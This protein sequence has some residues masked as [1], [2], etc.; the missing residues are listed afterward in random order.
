MP[1]LFENLGSNLLDLSLRNKLI[2]FTDSKYR[3]IEI[4]EPSGEKLFSIINKQTL[5]YLKNTE[6]EKITYS[7]PKLSY[8]IECYKNGEKSEK[9]YKFLKKNND[10]AKNEKGINILYIAFGLLN[11]KDENYKKSNLKSPLILIPVDIKYSF[12]SQLYTLLPIEDEIVL[13]PALKFKLEYDHGI[14]IP[15]FDP[16][17]G[18]NKYYESLNEIFE[19][20]NWFIEDKTFLGLFSFAKIT[21]YKDLKA[22]ETQ[23]TSTTLVETIYNGTPYFGNKLKTDYEEY[24]KDGKDAD[25]H[26]VVDTDSSQIEA[27]LEAKNG[28]SFVIQ[29]PPGTG[30]SQTITNIIAE[31]IN[32]KKRVLFVSEKK[33]ALDVV[34]NNLSKVGLN[35]FCLQIHSDKTNKKEFIQELYRVYSN[36]KYNPVYIDA[37]LNYL[38]NEKQALDNYAYLSNQYIKELNINLIDLIEKYYSYKDYSIDTYNIKNINNKNFK[39]LESCQKALQNLSLFE[40]SFS[41]DDYL[42]KDFDSEK[43]NYDNKNKIADDFNDYLNI[44]SNIV[45]ASNI[46][47]NVTKKNLHNLNNLEDDFEQ[48]SI[49]KDVPYNDI[50]LFSFEKRKE[51]ISYFDEMSLIIKKLELCEKKIE[52]IFDLNFFNI[53]YKDICD[54]FLTKYRN[55]FLTFN[56]SYKKDKK[57][58]T[59]YI[60]PNVK[61]INYF[62]LKK[63]IKNASLLAECKIELENA[64]EH[65]KKISKYNYDLSSYKSISC[66]YNELIKFDRKYFSFNLNLDEGINVKE[67]VNSAK[68]LSAL[69]T[70]KNIKKLKT[71]NDYFVNKSFNVLTKD[72]NDFKNELENYSNNI[73]KLAEW[74]NFYEIYKPI[75]KMQLDDFI[76]NVSKLNLNKKDLSNIY[77]SLFYKEWLNYIYYSNNT[78]KLM[79]KLKQN[80]NVFKFIEAD[81]KMFDVNRKYII[82][83]IKKNLNDIKD[84][85][86]GNSGFV[87]G[88]F[89]PDMKMRNQIK[90]LTHEANKKRAI[91]PIR[92]VFDQISDLLFSIKPCV[93]MSPV[94]VA[95][96]LKYKTDLFDV[97]IFDEASQ[98]FP[99]DAVGSISRAKSAII[100]GDS[101]QM[102]PSNFFMSGTSFDEEEK[103]EQDEDTAKDFESILDLA[104]AVFPQKMLNWHYRSK[105][106]SLIAFSNHNFYND[107]LVTFPS[108][109]FDSDDFGIKFHYVEN[110]TFV[111][112]VNVE[113]ANAVAD[114]VYESL[115][116]YPDKSI[117]VVCFSISQQS[118]LEDVIEERRRKNP[119]LDKMLTENID[120]PFFIKNLETVQGDERDIIIFSIGYGKDSS[121][122]F[123]MNFGPL[124]KEG[125]ERRLNVAI[126]RAK[127]SVHVVSSIRYSDID[128]SRTSSKGASLLKDYLYIAE[129]GI[130]NINNNI[131][132][133]DLENNNISLE[134]DIANAIKNMGYEAFTKIGHSD[135]KIDVV[136][137]HPKY[138]D[139]VLAIECDG[140]TYHSAKNTRDRDRLRQEVLEKQGW[141]FYRIWSIDWFMYPITEKEYLKKAIENAIEKYDSEVKGKK[142]IDENSSDEK[143]DIFIPYIDSKEEEQNKRTKKES[144][145]PII[146]PNEIENK[147][148]KEFT[149]NLSK[150]DAEYIASFTNHL[151]LSGYNFVFENR[152][153][154]FAYKL[155]SDI[156]NGNSLALFWFTLNNNRKLVL[157]LKEDSKQ[158]YYEKEILCSEYPSEKS[159][160]NLVLGYYNK[161]LTNSKKQES[162]IDVNEQLPVIDV[163]EKKINTFYLSYIDALQGKRVYSYSTEGQIIRKSRDI[164]LNEI[165]NNAL[166]RKIFKDR[167]DFNKH[168]YTRNCTYNIFDYYFDINNLNVDKAKKLFIY[169]IALIVMDIF[170]DYE[171]KL[172]CKIIDD[173]M[174]AFNSLVRIIESKDLIYSKCEGITSNLSFISTEMIDRQIEEY[175][176]YI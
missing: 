151:K 90:I 39:Y 86:T 103:Y 74:V 43:Y 92:K 50:N 132:N 78:F 160:C 104:T 21:M 102:P 87:Y 83:S 45:D 16:S 63:W 32:D 150:K 70:D 171:K 68:S 117:G 128:L 42:W 123:R 79:S 26:N 48:I 137:K 65:I 114:L 40:G 110:G 106:E 12:K 6:D 46:Y 143:N 142:E 138:D 36:T 162:I 29:G 124:N 60:N 20:K 89:A 174:K 135:Y 122:F 172:R 139:Y 31:L 154:I 115:L 19:K 76:K 11:W 84:A 133:F 15:E 118:L 173:N 134:E 28:K 176:K 37:Q 166:G 148:N 147:N 161:K 163:N 3:S 61:H 94:S 2:N 75:K 38:K 105:S 71:I 101:K 127:Y 47:N 145:K 23:M 51:L 77:T 168:K 53:N 14:K 91:M 100:V 55:V 62:N 96:Y 1:K 41:P 119:A 111:N 56:D 80:N 136:V 109:H 146:V 49:I 131:E 175:L 67:F 97:V 165:C 158:K 116:K 25:L 10:L 149:D 13:N 169:S 126:T 152:K 153:L 54:N 17:L 44:V 34:Y 95:T 167:E 24:F 72:I 59:R 157:R 82:N 35:D 107:K 112:R 4:I 170:K 144:Q 108:A 113:E 22:N 9:V 88:A 69:L 33:A 8:L 120:E 125:G 99:W 156:D 155:Q 141:N 66:I 64:K 140:K 121:G 129:K 5:I 85:A 73:D 164:I 159:L 58:F 57:Y 18:L 30:K 52:N 98:I 7:Y 27:I 81:K 93:L 130:N